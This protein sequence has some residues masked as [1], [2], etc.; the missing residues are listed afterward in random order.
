M[1]PSTPKFDTNVQV[2]LEKWKS[3]HFVAT[4]Q[5]QG[6]LDVHR[7]S[8][9]A[10][11]VCRFP[12]IVRLSGE[13]QETGRETSKHPR[14]SIAVARL[15]ALSRDHADD[16]P[17]RL[18]LRARACSDHH[19]S[20]KCLH[21]SM[22]RHGKQYDMD[23]NRKSCTYCM[24]ADAFESATLFVMLISVAGSPRR[25]WERTHVCISGSKHYTLTRKSDQQR[26]VQKTH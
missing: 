22:F 11:P 13:T 19:L 9:A 12:C 16:S 17:L 26:D 3:I 10:A 23:Q 5:P 4:L 18:F 2:L 21:L 14:V 24:L 15:G 1:P 20:C 6:H 7:C 25:F 8:L